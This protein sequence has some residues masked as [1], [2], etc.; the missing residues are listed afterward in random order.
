LNC[1]VFHNI[2]TFSPYNTGPEGAMGPA[3]KIDYVASGITGGFFSS[4]IVTNYCNDF[5]ND[6]QFAVVVESDNRGPGY[7]P[8]FAY[9]LT[10]HLIIYDCEKAEWMDVGAFTSIPGST[11]PTGM[12]DVV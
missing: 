2:E 10:G 8:P 12:Y 11:G 4:S 6:Q 9:N 7:G 5:S 1:F 3:F